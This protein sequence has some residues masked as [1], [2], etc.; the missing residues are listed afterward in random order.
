MVLNSRLKET[1][2]EYF[3]STPLKLIA[4]WKLNTKV[5][6]PSLVHPSSFASWGNPGV[7]P[8]DLALLCGGLLRDGEVICDASMATM[9]GAPCHP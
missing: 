9:T 4:W 2:V 6:V 8:S 7:R 3:R 5:T 1:L